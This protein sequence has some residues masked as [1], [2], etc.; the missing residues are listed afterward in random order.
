ML[1]VPAKIM[2]FEIISLLNANEFRN[3]VLY[4]KNSNG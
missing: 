4:E 1:K 3:F 2:F